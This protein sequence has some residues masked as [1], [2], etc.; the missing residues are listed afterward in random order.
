MILGMAGHVDHGKTAAVRQLSG[1]DVE[2][3]IEKQRGLT[4]DLGFT[5]LSTV[6]GKVAI[7]DVPGHES[8]VG[9]MLAGATGF[10]CVLL[11]IS[12]TE[13]I[14]RQTVEHL[15]ILQSLGIR[16]I[17]VLLTKCD[18]APSN[19]HN[20]Q[21]AAIQTLFEQM[22]LE[23]PKVFPVSS[24]MPFGY[25]SVRDWIIGLQCQLK[26]SSE[27]F[28][29]SFRMP[30]DRCFS[31][32]GHGCIVTGVVWS[33]KVAVG[34]SITLLPGMTSGSVR[35]LE[36][37]HESRTEVHAG[38]RAAINLFRLSGRYP[39]R[40]TEIVTGDLYDCAHSSGCWLHQ[41]NPE[42]PPKHEQKYRLHTATSKVWAKLLVPDG[43]HANG[44]AA[45]LKFDAPL[46]VEAGQKFV[47]RSPD[48]KF[49][50][51]GGEFLCCGADGR[52]KNRELLRLIGEIHAKGQDTVAALE[53]W[54][55]ST[56]EC[57]GNP[58]VI[59]KNL[60]GEIA[61][62]ESAIDQMVAAGKIVQLRDDSLV[63]RKS[64]TTIQSKIK[65]LLSN[66]DSAGH[67]QVSTLEK[68]LCR[69]HSTPAVEYAL[70][71]LE[72]TD[73]IKL[74]SSQVLIGAEDE[75]LSQKDQKLL[76]RIMS[77]YVQNRSGPNQGELIKQL[78]VRGS[79]VKKILRY[80][81]LKGHLIRTPGDFYFT[82]EIICKV[83]Q[84]LVAQFDETS[85]LTVTGV[86]DHLKLTRKHIIP[87]LEYFDSKLLTQR[88]G[89]FR[90]R[91]KKFVRVLQ[92]HDICD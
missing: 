35:A 64:L 90:L 33:G 74:K 81:E 44:S 2:R 22:K 31:Q 54:A 83:W 55:N 50:L 45:I 6:H 80:A 53:V 48:A 19:E 56:E 58:V 36:S 14:Q 29:Q 25:D 72:K 15:K 28:T 68:R 3:P 61:A 62:I 27:R 69:S 1:V 57:S 60:G 23:M 49:T 4:I 39:K 86:R 11:A 84:Q 10:D 65:S 8:F 92:V 71:E 37:Q 21:I 82:P 38:E 76:K 88:N 40:G 79:V 43:S 12:V 77:S 87:L 70:N 13:G 34:D 32:V 24:T 26:P 9:N 47:L 85:E 73:E 63:S 75:Q 89:N 91:G 42:M 59:K 7:V 20:V 78:G 17:G 16:S 5:S 67:L 30:V 51:A 52:M 66:S 46:V 41:F 18:L